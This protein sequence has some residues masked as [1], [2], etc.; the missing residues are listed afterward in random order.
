ML[1]V[2]CMASLRLHVVNDIYIKQCLL[3]AC[4]QAI[5]P[6]IFYYKLSVAATF[7]TDAYFNPAKTTNLSFYT[8]ISVA[9]PWARPPQIEAIPFPPPLLANS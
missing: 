1:K 5:L 7:L 9:S 2:D 4:S 6:E 3:E 8:S